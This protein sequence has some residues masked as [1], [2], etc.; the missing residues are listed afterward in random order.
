MCSSHI[1]GTN[2]RKMKFW[3][4]PNYNNRK[5][6]VDKIILHYTAID[7]KQEVIDR[8]LD[9]E[10]KVSAHYLVDKEGT[11]DQFVKEELRAW[12]AGVSFWRDNTDVNS[13]SIGIEILNNGQEKYT[14]K[15]I[16]SVLSLVKKIKAKYKVEDRNIIG[17]QD[18]APTRKIDPGT[19]FP[20]EDFSQK[21]IGLWP[22]E[23]QTLDSNLQTK[24]IKELFSLYGYDTA[25][26]EATKKAFMV[27]FNCLEKDIKQKLCLLINSL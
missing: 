24:D 13:G 22:K 2:I 27:H 10:S 12:H 19:F 16:F 8:F 11:V 18:V 17:H 15:Q 25:N 20:W 23:G 9:K 14:N 21:G 4:S 7:D 6:S 5:S 3:E 1:R 26:L